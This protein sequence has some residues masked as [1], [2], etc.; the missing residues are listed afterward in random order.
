MLLVSKQMVACSG[1]SVDGEDNDRAGRGQ[2]MAYTGWRK[3][4]EQ[5]KGSAGSN[6]WS[7]HTKVGDTSERAW[8]GELSWGVR[9]WA[10]AV[11][12]G[13]GLGARGGAGVRRDDV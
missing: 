6:V 12:A 11:L 9:C 5:T 13:S 8:A 3:N 4:M 2:S 7:G 1:G 10:M